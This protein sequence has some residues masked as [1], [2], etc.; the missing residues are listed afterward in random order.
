MSAIRTSGT[1]RP[2]AEYIPP[3]AHLIGF[4]VGRDTVEM[5]WSRFGHGVRFIGGHPNGST[6]W[7]VPNEHLYVYSDGFDYNAHGRVIDSLEI[8]LDN[9][10]E[11]RR[12]YAVRAP[13]SVIFANKVRIGMTR[14][15]VLRQL[16]SKLGPPQIHKNE[17]KWEMP[18]NTVIRPP[19]PT[20]FFEGEQ[21]TNWTAT[22]T[23]EKNVLTDILVE[24]G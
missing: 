9:G 8:S 16:K 21:Y 11:Q 6:A 18:G 19:N 10:P 15:E 20:E 13:R 24:C 22:L 4:V 23:F 14:S 12:M 1:T 7:Y 3:I 17:L 5:L 2:H